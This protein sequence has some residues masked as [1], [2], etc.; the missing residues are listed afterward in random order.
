[1][2]SIENF[3]LIALISQTVLLRRTFF[4]WMK[5]ALAFIDN[6]VDISTFSEFVKIY[7]SGPY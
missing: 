3:R 1:M 5:K 4:F 7:G 2:T 6:F